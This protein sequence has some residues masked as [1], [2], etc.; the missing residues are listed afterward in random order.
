MNMIENINVSFLGKGWSFPPSF[1]NAGNEVI[2][3]QGEPDIQDSLKILLSTSLGERIMQPRYGCNLS[4]LL[5][6]TLD[7]T[8]TTELKNRI[9][10]GIL[11]FEPR[12]DVEKIELTPNELGGL[13]LISIDYII[14]TT[15]TRGNLVYPFYLT[16]I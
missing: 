4:D 12:I 10:N 2:M 16:E 8:L 9:L 7:T 6:D 14:R 3:R 15:N 11:F 1:D 5:F 13:V